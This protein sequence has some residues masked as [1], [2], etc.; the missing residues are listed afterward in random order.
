MCMKILIFAGGNGTRLW[1][2]SRIKTPK[3]FQT[4]VGHKSLFELTVERMLRRYEWDDIYVVIPE[5]YKQEVISRYPHIKKDHIIIE[6][7]K[8]DTLAC[9]G[10]ASFIMNSLFPDETVFFVWSDHIIKHEDLF[11]NIIDAG[12]LYA[13][14]QHRMIKIGAKA[15]SPNVNLGYIKFG[16][17]IEKVNNIKI[18]AFEGHHEKP[19]LS[20][21]KQFV[22]SFEYL[23]NT[24]YMIWPVAML[25]DA[26]KK[27]SPDTYAILTKIADP[28]F[29]GNIKEEYMKIT[30][31]SIDYEILE[32][33]DNDDCVVIP[34]DVGWSDVGDWDSLKTQ[35]ERDE[36]SNVFMGTAKNFKHL[37]VENSIIYSYDKKKT[38]CLIGVDDLA[39]IDTADALLICAKKR[40]K[41]VKK[42]VEE[43]AKKQPELC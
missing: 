3:Q 38:I 14:G 21:A 23:W 35:L 9:I 30:K 26:Y 1:P 10:Y 11:L 25:I 2:V 6:P 29:S 40:S 42:I 19:E 37:D 12:D 27:Y 34:A 43:L 5:I 31:N 18:Y 20:L 41:D 28:D 8:W 39:V 32:K 22:S 4:L 7:C 13:R 24:G 36:K 15:T 17:Q 33:M 16:G